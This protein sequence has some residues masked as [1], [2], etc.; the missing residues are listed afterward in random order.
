M[1]LITYRCE[2]RGHIIWG[3]D[4]VSNPVEW[5]ESVTKEHPTETYLIVWSMDITDEE[6]KRIDGALKGM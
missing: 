1:K 5:L 4:V 2:S 6:A 3:Q